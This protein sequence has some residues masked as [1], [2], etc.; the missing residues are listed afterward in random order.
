MHLVMAFIGCSF[1]SF[2]VFLLSLKQQQNLNQI[3]FSCIHFPVWPYPPQIMI[4][5]NLILVNCM[6]DRYEFFI[7]VIVMQKDWFAIIKVKVTVTSEGS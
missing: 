1:D 4:F 2:S 6:V 5:I 7:R 3:M